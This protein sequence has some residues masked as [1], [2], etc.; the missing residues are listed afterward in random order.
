MSLSQ[1]DSDG[2]IV[3]V[4]VDSRSLSEIGNWPWS[5]ELHAALLNAATDAGVVDVLFDFDFAFPGDSEGD[6]RFVEALER[7]GGTTYLAVFEQIED[8]MDVSSRYVNLP[9]SAFADHSWPALVNV[10]AD[11][12]GLVRQ[13]PFGALFGDEYFPSAGAL[14]SGDFHSSSGRFDIDFSIRA[15]SIPVIP[16]IDLLTGV[17]SPETLSGRSVIFGASAIE[18]SDQLAVPVQGIISGP[19]LHALAAE[20]LSRG[21]DIKWLRSEWVLLILTIVVFSLQKIAWKKPLLFLVGSG[22]LFLGVE[23][24][25]ILA[26]RSASIM[27]PSVALHVGLFGFAVLALARSVQTRNWLLQKKSSESRN[28]LRLL[29]HVF[30]DASDGIVILGKDGTVIRHSASATEMF[31]ADAEGQLTL[32]ERLRRAEAT[33]RNAPA[34]MIEILKGD[35]RKILEYRA[36]SST[37]ELPK[38]VGKPPQKEEITTIVLRDVTELK[39][40]AQDIAYLSNYDDRTGALRRNAFSIFLNMRLERSGDT[41]VFALTLDRFKTVNVTLGRVVGDAVLKEVVGRLERS[42]L[43]LS[44]PVRLGGTSFAFYTECPADLAMADQIANDV[45]QDIGRLYRLESVNAQVGVRIGY[46]LVRDKSG[47]DAEIAL[48]QA[49]EAMDTTKVT[50]LDIARYDHSAWKKQR[51]AREIE[52]ALEGALQNGEFQMCYQPQHRVSDR[53]LVG[54]EALIRWHSPTMGQIPPDEFIGIA[55]STGFVVDLGK[56][57]LEQAAKDALTL[58]DDVM[59]AVNVSGIQLL[60]SNLVSDVADILKKTGLPPHQLCLELTETVLLN[61]STSIIETMQDL[62]FLGVTWALDDFGTGFSSMEYL[63]KMPLDKVKLDKSFVMQLG[64]DPA[65]RAILHSTSELCR[66]LGVKLLCE[67][68]ETE[69]QL[70]VLGEEGCAE[71]QGYYF[72]RPVPIDQLLPNDIQ[73]A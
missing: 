13:Y 32:P 55:E 23:L 11:P 65:A 17:I 8:A 10:H 21:L 54:A 14:M 1:K 63:S 29:E 5:R 30:D 59:I 58:P 41:I 27:V 24:G 36:A 25:G 53:A 35:D 43:R 28:T 15:S 70:A 47:L 40:Q 49:V 51:R 46:T 69:S 38:S 33:E 37:I 52:R 71:A 45:L 39:E 7:A 67:G 34:R 61:S 66:G 64:D 2:Q 18:L 12:Q 9:L 42:P 22:V 31:G 44:A 26:F 48:E 60:K 56:W 4:A 62:R 20:T 6:Q 73:H 72:G 57:T 3:F 50:G 68:V 16:A 19:L